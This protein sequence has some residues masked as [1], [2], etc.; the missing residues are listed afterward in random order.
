MD[1]SFLS[2]AVEQGPEVTTVALS[3]EVDLATIERVEEALAPMAH[4]RTLVMDLRGLTFMDSTG[5]RLLLQL[6]LRARAEG[7]RLVVARAP[8]GT[9]A[10]LLQLARMAERVTVVSDPAE[11]A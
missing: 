5:L 8:G 2:V 4:G 10:D 3:G 9:V 1:A 7:W 11:L 6:D